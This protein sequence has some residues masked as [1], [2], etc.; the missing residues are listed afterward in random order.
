MAPANNVLQAEKL[1]QRAQ[2][3]AAINPIIQAAAID[4]CLSTGTLDDF[5]SAQ[6]IPLACT[7]APVVVF[8]PYPPVRNVKYHV[9]TRK[10][11]EYR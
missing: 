10:Q 9:P 5:A 3:S 4:G 6:G 1:K 7:T 11:R 8:T 2:N